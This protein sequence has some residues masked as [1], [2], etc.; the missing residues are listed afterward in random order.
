MVRG[1]KDDMTKGD[2]NGSGEHYGGRGR[3]RKQGAY[4]GK[5]ARK[6]ARAYLVKRKEQGAKRKGSDIRMKGSRMG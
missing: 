6:G 2:A 5:E 4:G 3:E 1:P